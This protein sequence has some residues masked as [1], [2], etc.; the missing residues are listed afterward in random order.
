MKLDQGMRA[1]IQALT[2]DFPRVWCA[3][4]D[5]D[6]KRL[7]HLLVKDVTLLKQEEVT[8]HVR[9][10]GGGNRTLRVQR[11]QPAWKMRQTPPDL[12]AAVDEL[13]ESFRRDREWNDGAAK[14]Q[15][16]T[17]FEALKPDDPVALNGRRRLSSMIFA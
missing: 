14:A 8:M 10:R 1:R 6:R 16:F 4:S 15:L 3:A 9:F 2:T 5:R 11:A 12:V 17:I 13:L 7:L